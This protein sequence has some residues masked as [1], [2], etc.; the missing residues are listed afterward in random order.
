M[1]GDITKL[2]VHRSSLGYEFDMPRYALQKY[3]R[4]FSVENNWKSQS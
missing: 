2:K 1:T 4:A 3:H